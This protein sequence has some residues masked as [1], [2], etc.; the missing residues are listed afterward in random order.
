MIALSDDGTYAYVG[1]F[2]QSVV[3]RVLLTSMSSDLTIPVG[4]DPT[5]GPYYAGY[6]AVQPGQAH[7]IAVSKY[8]T[9]PLL[10][11]WASR[12]VYLFDDAVP[13]ATSF[14]ALGQGQRVNLLAWS[15]DGVTLYSDEPGL[16]DLFALAVSASGL[17]QTHDLPNSPMGVNMYVVGGLIYDEYGRVVDPLAGAVGSFFAPDTYLQSSAGF[18]GTLNVAPYFFYEDSSGSQPLW[19]VQS[20]NLQQRSAV[21]KIR[22]MNIS[23]QTNSIKGSVTR[24]IRW[25]VNGLAMNAVEGLQIIN[26]AFV[27]N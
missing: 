7:T 1:F 13:R 5:Y 17:T 3:Q 15:T 19:T 24:V 6:L 23:G 22:L 10:S 14:G 9:S 26:G 12:G 21:A 11:D 16:G 8:A 2:D 20:F 4:I 27:T 25:G 18:D